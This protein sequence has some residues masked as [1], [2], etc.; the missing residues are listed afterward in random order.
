MRKFDLERALPGF[1]AAAENLENESGAIQNLGVPGLLQVALLNWRQGAIH[2]HEFDLVAGDGSYDLLDL[3]LAEVGGRANLAEGRNQRVHN[4]KINGARQAPRL[5]QSGLPVTDSTRIR[6]RIGTTPAHPRIGAD[7]NHPPGLFARY[8]PRTVGTP[9]TISGF[10]SVHSQAVA[11]SPPSN[12]W[13]GAP[14][15]MV[16]IACL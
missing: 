3:A 6:L 2:H 16:E 4:F 13:M 5:L 11:S 10:Q 7:D 9:V 14:G 8:R 1:G 15:I 12:N